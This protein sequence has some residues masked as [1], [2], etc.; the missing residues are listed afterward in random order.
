MS[1]LEDLAQA[2]MQRERQRLG[3]PAQEQAAAANTRAEEASARA[4]RESE[5]GLITEKLRQ[6]LLAGQVEDAPEDREMQR[7]LRR[8]QAEEYMAHAAERRRPKQ[9]KQIERVIDNGDH[10]LVIYTDGTRE[11]EPKGAAPRAHG[12]GGGGGEDVMAANPFPVEDAQGRQRLAVRVKGGGLKFVDQIGGE[13][14]SPKPP[15]SVIATRQGQKRA[16]PVLADLGSR[17]AKINKDSEGGFFE[18]VGGAARSGASR[19]GMDPAVDLY[20]TGTRGFTSLLARA[21]GHVGMLTELDVSR[22][23]ELFPRVGDSAQVTTEKLNRI[24]RIVT[25]AEPMPFEFEH[26]EYNDE[27]ITQAPTQAAP[28]Q[29]PSSFRV[30][31]VKK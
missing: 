10:N 14:V 2:Y 3:I 9:G 4:G 26:P 1:L 30:L 11:K 28:T 12:A 17:I 8:A 19:I 20:R 5:S 6:A 15:Q 13:D 31:G 23:E 7:M 18:R 27:G 21:V 29:S 25:G 22:T 16:L 24:K